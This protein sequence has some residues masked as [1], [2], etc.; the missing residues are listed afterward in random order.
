MFFFFTC[1]YVYLCIYFSVVPITVTLP[2]NLP[3]LHIHSLIHP[4]THII[5]A[6]ISVSLNLSIYQSL[7][8]YSLIHSSLS[9]IHSLLPLT[10]IFPCKL[11]LPSTFLCLTPCF[12]DSHNLLFTYFPIFII[13]FQHW[14]HDR[15]DGMAKERIYKTQ[16]CCWKIDHKMHIGNEWQ[17][18]SVKE[19]EREERNEKK[20]HS[21]EWGENK[22]RK[23]KNENDWCC[24][25]KERNVKK[26]IRN[27][28]FGKW[29]G[30][31]LEER[32]RRERTCQEWMKER[33]N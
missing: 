14:S 6:Q 8:V 7:H 31:E 5:L 12:S 21:G 29:R 10:S 28:M 24:S 1:L 18:S 32:K 15:R 22:E 11:H 16:K 9:N 25:I 3:V 23:N 4:E 17:G 13:F 30:R 2:Y 26:K 19:R 33:K 20:E 27:K